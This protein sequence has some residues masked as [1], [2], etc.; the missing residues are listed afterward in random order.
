MT[1]IGIISDFGARGSHYVAEMKGVAFQI[2]PDVQIIDITHNITPFSIR[3]AAYVLRT[4]YDTFPKGTIFVT[5][6]DPGVGSN[7]DILAIQT[8]DD[9]IFIGPNNGIFSYL[10]AHNL[11]AVAL[12]IEEEE[13][14][15][16]P[17]TEMIKER[18]KHRESLQEIENEVNV[19]D[20][21]NIDFL[22]KNDSIQGSVS[23]LETDLWAGTFHG[24]DIMM[25]I[26]CHLASGLEIFSVG[27][28]CDEISI[29][30]DLIP[31]FS[32]DERFILTKIQYCDSFGNLITNIPIG[33]FLSKLQQTAPF[34]HLHYKGKEHQLKISKIFAGNDENQLLFI[35][36]SSGFM[37]IAL[38]KGSAQVYL[39]AKVEDDLK[40]ELLGGLF[41]EFTPQL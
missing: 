27:S 25:P 11:I 37:E 32:E 17:F 28:V 18:R 7:R 26:A 5:V 39:D 12:K 23:S 21:I 2:N 16:P 36:G 31:C 10:Q 3:E 13:F 35:E 22:K 1:I 33:L 8:I 14:F 20:A 34:V 6:V 40:I 4:V 30:P 9:Y 41:S 38:N 19:P 29:I 24:R 15:Y